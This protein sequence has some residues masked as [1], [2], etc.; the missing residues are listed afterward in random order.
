MAAHADPHL[1]SWG[2]RVRDRLAEGIEHLVIDAVAPA[3]RG[4]A[5]VSVLLTDGSGPVFAPHP[6]G[7]LRELAFQ[8][9]F[10]AEA[11]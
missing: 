8:A 10:H 6:E 3:V 9:A 5:I 2:I 11:E 4:T 7:S 1:R